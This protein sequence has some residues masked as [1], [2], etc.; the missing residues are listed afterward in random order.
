MDGASKQSVKW[1]NDSANPVYIRAV[2]K[3]GIVTFELY[4]L[5]LGRK[6]TFSTPKVTGKVYAGDFTEYTSSLPAGAVERIEFPHPGM[7]VEVVRTVLDR[8]GALLHRETWTSHYNKVDGRT[9]VGSSS[10]PP[11]VTPTSAPGVGG[12]PPGRGPR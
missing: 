9:L 3:A 7:N 12:P 5:P 2:A 11:T 10:A 8:D 4:S 1:R 6:V